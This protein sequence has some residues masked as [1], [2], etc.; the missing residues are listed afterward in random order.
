[1][2]KKQLSR[3]RLAKM[4]IAARSVLARLLAA[5]GQQTTVTTAT[6]ATTLS[7]GQHRQTTGER[8]T[9]RHQADNL[10]TFDGSCDA[11]P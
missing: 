8:D 9:D 5:K 6:T 10:L 4:K 2:D 11:R 3:Q 7:G 1:M